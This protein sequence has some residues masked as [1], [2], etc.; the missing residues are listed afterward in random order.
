MI[1]HTLK[2]KLTK[3]Q[4]KLLLEYR[5]VLTGVYNWAIKRIEWDAEIGKYYSKMEFQNL[6]SG[7]SKRINVPSHV[8]QAQLSNAYSAW[9]RCF[10]KVSK[11]PRFKGKRNKIISILFSDPINSPISNHIKLPGLGSVKYHKQKLPQGEIKNASILIKASGYYLSVCIDAERPTI[12]RRASGA[13]GIDPGYKTLVTMSDGAKVEHPKEVFN[14]AARLAQAQ[15][16]KNKTLT[17][18][19]QERVANQKK[20][21]NHKLSFNLVRHFTEIYFSNDNISNLRKGL[22]GSS[23]LAA[24]HGQLKQMLKYK[25]TKCNTEY[26]EVDCKF[27][28]RT[29]SS[30][31]AITGPQGL[32]GLK[33]RHW[34][35]SSC[36]TTLDRDINA[37]INTLNVGRGSRH[38]LTKVSPK[39]VDNT[40]DQGS[41]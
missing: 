14:A 32:A 25:S 24:N 7:I 5:N 1:R 41:T 29:C 10:K 34:V 33:V 28:T 23:V 3:T 2:L 21:R 31:K 30:C 15:R 37:A 11:K 39:F 18:K 17:A 4:E 36:G 40:N 20:D 9:Q 16:G 35:C 13:I 22:F 12:K 6:L 38:E 8:L 26:V 27:S 19:L